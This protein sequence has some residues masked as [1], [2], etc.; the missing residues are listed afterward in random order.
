M[1]T[2]QTTTF[3]H[4]STAN[5]C[6]VSEETQSVA[7]GHLDGGIRFWDVRSGERVLDIPKLH[8]GGV[9]S[10]Q[11]NPKNSHEILTN[12]RDSSL[13]IIDARTSTA[14]ST[15]RDPD[16]R[17]MTNYASASFSPDAVYV[18]AGS[19]DNGD[20]FVWNVAKNELEKRL[21]GHQNGAVG[22]SWGM[23]GTNGQQVATIDKSGS[24][25]LWA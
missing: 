18:G 4:S 3:R 12:G 7:T 8:E 24:L 9:T 14:I 21:S 25:I 10:V 17:T 1:T 5:C 13:N 16:F 22:L 11:W 20:I 19:G 2:S 6:D 15:F 23:G